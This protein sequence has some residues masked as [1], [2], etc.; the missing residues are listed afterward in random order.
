MESEVYNCNNSK[1]GREYRR[2]KL[3]VIVPTFAFFVFLLFDSVDLPKQLSGRLHPGV[4]PGFLALIG[5][6][7]IASSLRGEKRRNPDLPCIPTQS[8]RT[9][10]VATAVVAVFIMALGTRDLGVLPT[11]AAAGAVTAW[12]VAGTSPG[13]A[14]AIGGGLALVCALVFVL[15]LRQPLPLLPRF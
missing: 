3:L 13:R 6:V 11:V 15:L 5:L 2:Y 14:A 10:P 4:V 8:I 12:G 9:R 7:A 1:E